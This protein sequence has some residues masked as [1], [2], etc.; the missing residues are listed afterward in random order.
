MKQTITRGTI[1]SEV[2]TVF[3]TDLDYFTVEGI[4]VFI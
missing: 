3:G 4:I 1:N 2:E